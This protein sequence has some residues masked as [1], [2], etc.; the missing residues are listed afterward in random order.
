MRQPTQQEIA[1]GMGMSEQELHEWEHAFQANEHESLADVYNQY[2]I[3]YA[4]E[5]DSPEEKLGNEELKQ[6]LKNALRTLSERETL[7]IQLYYIEELNVFE[8]AEVMQ[9]FH[10]VAFLK[11]KKSAISNLR[12]FISKAQQVG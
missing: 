3:W 1:T 12:L 9:K 2:S 5:E 7:V 10:Q 6:L 8:I 11:L 4:S